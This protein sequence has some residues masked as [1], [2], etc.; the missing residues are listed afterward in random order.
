MYLLTDVCVCIYTPP[1][2]HMYNKQHEWEL[3]TGT[4]FNLTEFLKYQKGSVLL[5][6][7]K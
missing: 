3:L 7:T 2:T 1:T 5:I 4:E 6:Y